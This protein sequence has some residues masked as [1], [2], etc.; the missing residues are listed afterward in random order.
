[1]TSPPLEGSLEVRV[2]VRLDRAMRARLDRFALEMARA[3]GLSLEQYSEL[4]RSDDTARQEL[5]DR[6]VV[7][8]TSFFRHPEQFEAGCGRKHDQ[9]C[10]RQADSL[11]GGRGVTKNLVQAEALYKASCDGGDIAG[12]Q[13]MNSRASVSSCPL[14]DSS[15]GAGA[16]NSSAGAN[17]AAAASRRRRAESL[18]ISSV[19]RRDATVISQPRGL[20]GTPPAGH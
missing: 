14:S 1:M 18:R 13:H 20:S 17:A 6:L 10:N 16:T 11:A 12:W 8:T 19:I 15:S 9:A 3:R 2:G 4:V 5:V 7:P